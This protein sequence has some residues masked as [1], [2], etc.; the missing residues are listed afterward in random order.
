MHMN[1]CFCDFQMPVQDAEVAKLLTNEWQVGLF[2]TCCQDPKTVVFSCMCA[3]CAAYSQRKD[4]MELTREPYVFAG[5]MLGCGCCS[6][7]CSDKWLCFEALC[8]LQ[9]AISGNRFIIQTRFDRRNTCYD[10]L[11]IVFTS[12]TACIS[13]YLIA[14][15]A[16]AKQYE[17]L[18][19][20]VDVLV[21]A[22][23]GCMLTQ[24]EVEIKHLKTLGYNGAGSHC[25]R[26]LPV[27]VQQVVVVRAPDQQEMKSGPV[28][29]PNRQ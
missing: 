22:V 17:G 14:C 29:L 4:L 7:P 16:D 1:H 24:Q 23:Q 21:C 20:C 6:K 11:I 18:E 15:C 9:F 8:C 3:P 27:G 26:L 25:L 2:Q 28:Y 5:G 10:S 12:V 19:H 13:S